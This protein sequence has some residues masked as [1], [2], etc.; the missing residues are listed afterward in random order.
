MSLSNMNEINALDNENLKKEIIRVSQELVN[1]RV[2][3]ATR[4]EFKPHE[5]KTNKL[6]LAQLLTVK[7]KNEIKQLTNK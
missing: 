5:F 1:L 7:T 3:K 4:Q 6:R 2:K